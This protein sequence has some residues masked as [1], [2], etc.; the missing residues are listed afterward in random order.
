M[1]PAEFTLSDDFEPA[2][3]EDWL[4]LV[5]EDPAGAS[6]Q[7]R[8]VTRMYEGIAI[9]PLYMQRGRPGE[10][11]RD[12]SEL[13]G[14]PP[15]TRGGRATGNAVGGWDIR[16]VHGNA[17]LA[18]LNR[19]ILDDIRGG[20]TSIELRLDAAGRAGLDPSDPRASDLAGRDGAMIYCLSD[21]DAALADVPLEKIGVGLEA[22][23]SFLPAASMLI[24]LLEKRRIGVPGANMAFRADPLATL[25]R[26]GHLPMSLD[27]AMTTMAELALWTS[28]SGCDAT[29]VGVD[30]SPYH[31]AGASA[32]QDLAFSIATGIEYLRVMERTGLDVIEAAEQTVFTYS[33]G[34]RLFLEMAK[35]RAARRLWSRVIESS[36]TGKTTTPMRMRVRSAARVHTVCD[37]WVN[38]LRNT[39]CCFAAAAGGAESITTS[40][41]DARIGEPDALSRRVARNTQ[42]L[43]RDESNLHRVVDTAGGS[44]FIEKLT[45]ELA[46]NA[47]TILQEIERKGG[48]AEALVSGWIAE[49]IEPVHTARLKNIAR[50]KDAIT[51]VSE[52]PNLSEDRPKKAPQNLAG[53]RSAAASRLAQSDQSAIGKRSDQPPG[54]LVATLVEAAHAGASIG[55]M[56]EAIRGSGEAVRIEPLKAHPNA[57]PYEILRDAS[58]AHLVARGNRP[59]VFLAN[60]G[61]LAHHTARATYAGNF[62]QAGGFEVITNTGFDNTDEAAAALAESGAAI[63][64]ICSSDK[65]YE[66]HVVDLAP[67]LKEAGAR[68]I[69]VAGR[70]GDNE[71]AYRDAGVDRFIYIG[72]DVLST[73]TDLL[74]EEG[75]LR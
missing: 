26:D 43:L 47:W 34:C 60:I 66:Q 1:L 32:T 71:K 31:D 73:L 2:T 75:V 42:L 52:F 18:A 27:D 5:D 46:E 54:K 53:L 41:F 58:D 63:V 45:D 24:A 50:R 65:L 61:P 16:Q 20:V 74:A 72:C 59:T 6:F 56:T 33:V 30:T 21:M 22:G 25:A 8:L 28:C 69:V 37:P 19:A 7:R 48:M 57:E 14:L 29:A 35:L 51:G 67:K 55:Q 40:P 4:A 36:T 44:W 38:I 39:I 64:A 23:A 11:G 9:Q 12:A 70:P 68:T 13:A 3:Y 49:Q 17:D 10:G 15:Y 62:F